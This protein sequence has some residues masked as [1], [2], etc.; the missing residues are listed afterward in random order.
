[1]LKKILGTTSAKG[2]NAILYMA[3]VLLS[4]NSFGTEGYGKITLFVMAVSLNAT[5]A[6]II[7]SS[8]IYLTSRSQVYKL[9]FVSYTFSLVAALIGSSVLQVFGSDTRWLFDTHR[10]GIDT[11]RVI[12]NQS[13]TFG[14]TWQSKKLQY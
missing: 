12:S 9:A 2:F 7:V 1:M 4:T 8:L 3:I 5:L 10:G 6:G 14:R 11:M 13:A